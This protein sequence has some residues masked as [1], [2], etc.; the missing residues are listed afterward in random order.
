[1]SWWDPWWEQKSYAFWDHCFDIKTAASL[2]TAVQLKYPPSEALTT[3]WYVRLI[4]QWI[5]NTSIGTL[6]QGNQQSSTGMP[7]LNAIV[8]TTMTLNVL[9]AQNQQL[10]RKT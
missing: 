7:N 1:M 9:V 2:E 5:I 8:Q 10:F 4:C 6:H 3:V